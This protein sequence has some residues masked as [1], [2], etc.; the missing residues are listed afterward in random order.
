MI[1]A[2]KNILLQILIHH[3]YDHPDSNIPYLILSINT[4]MYINIKPTIT[5]CRPNVAKLSINERKCL[6]KYEG[7]LQIFEHYTYHNCMLEVRRRELL[8]TCGCVP[9]YYYTCL[10]F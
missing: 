7:S 9:F 2:V 1:S 5:T 3:P 10:Y 8:K 6:F 4:A